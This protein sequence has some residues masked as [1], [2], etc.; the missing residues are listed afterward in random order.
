MLKSSYAVNGTDGLVSMFV[1][2]CTDGGVAITSWNDDVDIFV[3]EASCPRSRA[4][5]VF[6]N[7]RQKGLE[8]KKISS[9]FWH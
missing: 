4:V 8:I 5:T 3:G 9:L 1:H 2:I 6:K 7:A